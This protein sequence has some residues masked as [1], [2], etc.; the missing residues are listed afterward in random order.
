MGE[1]KL[2]RVVGQLRAFNLVRSIVAFNIQPLT[3]YNEYTFHFIEVVHTHLRNTRGKAPVPGM[4]AP[5][6]MANVA[7]P[8]MA[9][10]AQSGGY[11]NPQQPQQTQFNLSDT[12][13][14]FFNTYAT[15]EAGST[16]AE[17]FEAMKA[18]GASLQQIRESVDFLVG[19]G[20]LY[21]MIDDDHFKGT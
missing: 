20:H 5:R 21:S 13:L 19:E 12:V 6:G 4:A 1:G 17:C 9:N 11:G 8:G 15:T 2:V 14:E 16:V 10:G 18:R 7:Q 3:D